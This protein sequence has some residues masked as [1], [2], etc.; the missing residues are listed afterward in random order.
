MVPCCLSR[1]VSTVCCQHVH[2]PRIQITS[3]YSSSPIHGFVKQPFFWGEIKYLDQV[4]KCINLCKTTH[5][6]LKYHAKSFQRQKRLIMFLQL[7]TILQSLCQC[8]QKYV[9]TTRG[10][11]RKLHPT[12]LPLG[13]ATAHLLLL[14]ALGGCMTHK[15]TW[16][17]AVCVRYS[18]TMGWKKKKRKSN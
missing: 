16:H 2:E 3:V 6:Q 4:W 12:K 18:G 17:P 15:A 7:F 5:L 11:H 9:S 10:K 8:P 13:P 1:A 14:G